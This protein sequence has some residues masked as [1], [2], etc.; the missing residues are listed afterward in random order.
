VADTERND[1]APAF[2]RGFDG[3]RQRQM[4]AG[5]ALTPSQRL[6]WLED[7][8]EELRD[9]LGRARIKVPGVEASRPRRS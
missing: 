8:M 5:L 4:V 9:L 1:C 6:Q 2:D 3:H 7:A